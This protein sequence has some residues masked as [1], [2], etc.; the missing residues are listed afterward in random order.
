M[1]TVQITINGTDY[2]AQITDLAV[3]VREQKKQGQNLKG[4]T[5]IIPPRSRS[6]SGLVQLTFPYAS[7]AT[8]NTLKA[9]F[10]AGAPVTLGHAGTLDFKTG[11]YAPVDYAEAKLKKLDQVVYS[12]ILT[13]A[14][15]IPENLVTLQPA[16]RSDL[17]PAGVVQRLGL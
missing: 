6:T 15:D 12:V 4:E 3:Q 5:T 14:E 10:D 13:F 11:T 8:R 7:L 1:A 2:A 9:L 17:T 16:E